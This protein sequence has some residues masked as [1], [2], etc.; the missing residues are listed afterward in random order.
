MKK[1]IPPILLLILVPA[2][3]FAQVEFDRTLPDSI[4]WGV[5]FSILLLIMGYRFSEGPAALIGSIILGYWGFQ[6][7]EIFHEK[8]MFTPKAVHQTHVLTILVILVFAFLS[9]LSLCKRRR[10]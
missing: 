2:V 9:F 10:D 3:A 7:W 1:I 5:C 6:A 8:H 4:S